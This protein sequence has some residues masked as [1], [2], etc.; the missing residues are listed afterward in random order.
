MCLDFGREGDGSGNDDLDAI[1]GKA[2]KVAVM[3]IG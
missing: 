2:R 1:S 3:V